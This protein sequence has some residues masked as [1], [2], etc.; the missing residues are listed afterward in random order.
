MLKKIAIAGA[1][2]ALALAVAGCDDDD[3]APVAG[4][5]AALSGTAAIGAPL[6]NAAVTVMCANASTTA[7]STPISVVTLADGKFTVTTTQMSDAK[8]T[9]PCALRVVYDANNDGDTTD[10]GDFL[11]SVA[12]ALGTVNITPLTD[13]AVQEAFDVA[14]FDPADAFNP[15]SAFSSDDI[16]AVVAQLSTAAA[17]LATQI[18]NAESGTATLPDIFTTAFNADGVSAYDRWLDLLATAWGGAYTTAIMNQ[19][20]AGTYVWPTVEFP[21]P[22]GNYNL[23]ISG[24]YT[25]V[26]CISPLQVPGLSCGTITIPEGVQA[27]NVPFNE[28]GMNMAQYYMGASGFSSTLV[29]DTENEKVYNVVL[30]YGGFGYNLTYRYVKVS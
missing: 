16:P 2:S 19:W 1:L 13:L 5:V 29:T 14:G 26:P 20:T 10:A 3:D 24:S 8:G 4:P 25:G 11:Y 7:D 28:V 27:Q 17:T 21:V 15:A 9:A 18:Q 22:T 6:P 30:N 12:Q 23:F